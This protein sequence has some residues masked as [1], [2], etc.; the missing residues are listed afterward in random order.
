M[1]KYILDANVVFS[2]LI[3]GKQLFIELFEH[4]QF[5]APDFI[6]VELDKYRKVLLKKSKLPAEELQPYIRKLFHQITVVPAFYIID[7]HKIKAWNLCR[8]IDEKDTAYVALSIDMKYPLV[9]R[10][11]KLFSGL[12]AKG[13]NHVVL[14]DEIIRNG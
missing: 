11:Q 7:E 1:N 8:D 4:N 3:N 13:F 14:L 10:D 12:K 2:A 9:T 6:F 5:F